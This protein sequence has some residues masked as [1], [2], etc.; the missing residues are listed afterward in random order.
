M[1]DFCVAGIVQQAEQPNNLAEGQIPLWLRLRTHRAAQTSKR[2]AVF[3]CGGESP[4]YLEG[5]F[6]PGSHYMSFLSPFYRSS[7]QG[8]CTHSGLTACPPEDGEL[9]SSAVNMVDLKGKTVN[10]VYLKEAS[11]SALLHIAGAAPGAPW[12]FCAILRDASQHR[13]EQQLGY[14]NASVS[15]SVLLLNTGRSSIWGTSMLLYHTECFCARISSS[16]QHRQEQHLGHLNASV[17]A[18]IASIPRLRARL[19]L[20]YDQAQAL[21]TSHQETQVVADPLLVLADKVFTAKA[22]LQEGRRAF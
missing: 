15:H 17:P 1:G 16:S 14:L 7:A 9:N 22:I 8:C 6:V 20:N 11:T 10:M 2:T 3:I 21:Q 5:S 4:D 19:E 12:C 13:Q 18:A